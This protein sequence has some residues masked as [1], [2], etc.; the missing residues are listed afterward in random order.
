[1]QVNLTLIFLLLVSTSSW[2]QTKQSFTETPLFQNGDNGYACYRIPAIIKANNGD[3]LAFAEGRVKG[4]NDFGNVDIVFKR[5]TDHGQTWSKQKVV[6][7]HGLLQAGNPAPVLDALDPSYS[8]GKLFLFYNTGTASEHDTRNGKGIREVWYST[9]TDHGLT[10]S[11][12]VNITTQVH[13]PNQPSFNKA[14]QFKEDWRTHA[15]TPGHA[16]QLKKGKYAGRIFV[17]ANHSAGAPQKGFN[18]YRAY[19]FY[20]DD[21]GLSWHIS[22]E[23]YIPSSNEA[24]AAE[25]SDGRVMLNCRHQNG[26]SKKRI[27]TISNDG[28]TSWDTTYF[29]DQLPS[30]VCQA[31]LLS[32]TT[33]NNENALLFS[34][35]ANTKSRTNM[36]VKV[37][38]D[39][40]VTWEARREIR[41]G[42]SAYSDLVQLQNGAIGLLYEHGNNGGIHYAQF[43]YDWLLG[44]ENQK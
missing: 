36:T 38:Y 27:V 4:C 16:L 10:W 12:G 25:L 35:P 24:I 19:A 18:E 43:N 42:E 3:L 26:E 32:Y 44:D 11:K 7:D 33:P 22:K 9:S 20:S 23:I 15:N 2:S 39:D 13:K 31:S 1:M 40:G 6:V 8:N 28:G 29:D 34:N 17:P 5:S 41:S 14:Y 21:H 37:S 30:P